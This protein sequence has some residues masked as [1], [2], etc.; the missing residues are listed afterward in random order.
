MLPQKIHYNSVY[1]A[2]KKWTSPTKKKKRVRSVW[3]V[4]NPHSKSRLSWRR[5]AVGTDQNSHNCFYRECL[6]DKKIPTK[7]WRSIRHASSQDWTNFNRKYYCWNLTVGKK[8]CDIITVELFKYY[9]RKKELKKFIRQNWHFVSLKLDD[10]SAQ[11][12]K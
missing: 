8:N 2:N 10:E 5:N 11:I 6:V 12:R 9:T 7:L 1:G 4:L 3:G